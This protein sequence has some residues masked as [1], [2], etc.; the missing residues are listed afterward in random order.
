[1]LAS[2]FPELLRGLEI[3]GASV[4]PADGKPGTGLNH[5]FIVTA[6]HGARMAFQVIHQDD[7]TQAGDGPPPAFP[8]AIEIQSDRMQCAHVEA[9]IAA[10]IG[11]SPAAPYVRSIVRYSDKE[12]RA[13]HFGLALDLH[14]GGRVF[15][16]ALWILGPDEI[17]DDEN[18]HRMRDAV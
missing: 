12:S 8:E 4:K 7:G 17:P 13:I 9:G 6:Q 5:G 2:G 11:T 1:M 10:W 14:T 18:K 15:I 3:P 16:Q